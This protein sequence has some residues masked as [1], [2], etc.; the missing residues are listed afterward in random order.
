[1]PLRMR[2]VAATGLVVLLTG[3]TIALVA[4]FATE[5][6]LGVFVEQIGDD[7]ADRLAL[8][9]SRAYT[10]AGGWQTADVLLAEAGYSYPAGVDS[11]ESEAGEEN[12]VEIF[13][14]ESDSGC[15]RRCRRPRGAGQ[16]RPT[17]ARQ[18]CAWP[19]RSQ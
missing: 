6:R 2:I 8:N 14:Q 5:S 11:S 7:E 19:R 17:G 1:M 13:H 4:Y 9:L 12:H 15:D 16:L 3:L 18:H 10:E